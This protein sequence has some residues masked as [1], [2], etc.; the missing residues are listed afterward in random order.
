MMSFDRTGISIAN[1]EAGQMASE[2]SHLARHDDIEAGN[3]VQEDTGRCFHGA[4]TICCVFADR[5]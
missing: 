2:S 3:V 1:S 5:I 4:E